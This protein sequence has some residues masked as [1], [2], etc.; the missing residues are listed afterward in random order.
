MIRS[1]TAHFR[2]PIEIGLSDSELRAAIG[3]RIRAPSHDAIGRRLNLKVRPAQDLRR[4]AGVSAARE[5]TSDDGH[6]RP[7]AETSFHSAERSM[8]LLS[9]IL[10]LGT[11]IVNETVNKR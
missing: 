9:A 2:S 10:G 7:V 11:R 6:L 5:Q 3:R 1:G 4:Q 8:Q